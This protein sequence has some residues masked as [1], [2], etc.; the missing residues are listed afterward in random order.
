MMIV[1]ARGIHLRPM[2]DAAHILPNLFPFATPAKFCVSAII[3]FIRHVTH[4][5]PK[6]VSLVPPLVATDSASSGSFL[7]RSSA[8]SSSDSGSD[9]PSVEI[10]SSETEGVGAKAQERYR[11]VASLSQ[12]TTRLRG[13]S[14]QI[15]RFGNGEVAVIGPSSRSTSWDDGQSDEHTSQSKEPPV[16]F[17]GD[18]TV[19]EHWVRHHY[20]TNS[21]SHLIPT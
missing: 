2:I 13:R 9:N 20:D 16:M 18:G 4:T 19:Y 21:S 1:L 8:D 17:A 5:P 11:I 7:A 6:T 14:A 15:F 12:A 10:H 3:S